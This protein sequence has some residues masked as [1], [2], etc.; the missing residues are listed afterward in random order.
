MGDPLENSAS[1]TSR[2]PCMGKKEWRVQVAYKR[3]QEDAT[4]IAKRNV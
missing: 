3:N 4:L 2:S 1:A